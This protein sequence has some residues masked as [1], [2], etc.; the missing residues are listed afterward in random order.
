M[1]PRRPNATTASGDLLISS[2]RSFSSKSRSTGFCDPDGKRQEDEAELV[3]ELVLRLLRPEVHR[4]DRAELEARGRRA[5]RLEVAAERPR[6]GREEDV[7]HGRAEGLPRRLHLLEGNR[8]GP[9]RALEVAERPLERRRRVG[10]H[11]EEPRQS[12]HAARA[13]G[14]QLQEPLRMGQRLRPLVHQRLGHLE[15]ARDRLRRRPEKRTEPLP[16]VRLVRLA[17]VVRFRRRRPSST[18]GRGRGRCRRRWSG[19]S[20]REARSR[21]PTPSIRWYCQS[22]FE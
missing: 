8:P 1:A 21:S 4:D 11:Q 7:V 19:G 18:G 6:H 20:G 10:L 2:I 14:G 3:A 5:V 12:V 22:G 9:R 16:A 17:G 15:R 13:A